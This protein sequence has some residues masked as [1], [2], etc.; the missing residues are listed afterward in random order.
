MVKAKTE[1][2]A[3]KIVR[4]RDK[5]GMGWFEISQE[6]GM[7]Q[8]KCQVLYFSENLD[9][10]DV[11]KFKD[12]EDAANKIVKLRDKDNVSWGIIGVRMNISESKVRR[13]YEEKTGTS[14]KGNRIGKGGRHPGDETG[15]RPAKKAAAKKVAAKKAVPA[16]KAAKAT[17]STAKKATAEPQ[18]ATASK[19]PTAMNLSELQ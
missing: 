15:T 10:K 4:L 9:P 3:Q 18:K 17:K 14:T 7:G 12:D 5:D 13:L 11:V 6:M 16:K 1:T 8:G 2:D 19:P